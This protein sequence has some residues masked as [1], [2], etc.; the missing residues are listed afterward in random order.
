[1]KKILVLGAG[2]SAPYLIHHLLEHAAEAGTEITV[3]DLDPAAAEARVAG[4]PRG[5]AIPFNLDDAEARR[6]ELGNADLVVHLLPPKLQ[7]VLARYCLEHRCHMASA[8]YLAPEVAEMGDEAKARGVTLLCEL[9]L[10]PGIDLMSAQKIIE[11]A[12]AQGG[13]VESFYSYG[14]GLPEP[15][16]DG[17]PMRYCITWN[18]RNVAM[19][20]E[21]G[22]QYLQD[23]TIKVQPWHRMFGA[24]WP[25]EV[26][27]LGRFD[28]YPNRDSVSYRDTHGLPGVRTL[29][30]GT[31]RYPGFCQAWHQVVRLGLPSEALRIPTLGGM[32]WAQVLEMYLPPGDGTL[33]GRVARTLDLREDDPSLDTLEWLGLFGDTA[34]DDGAR[35][36]TD[37]LVGLMARKLALPDGVRDLVVLHHELEIAYGDRRER[38]LST[39]AH[40]G[41]P[42]GF[43]AMAKGVGLPLALG[44]ELL[45]SGGLDQ[46]GCLGPTDAAVYGPVLDGLARDGLA[47]TESV[48]TL[49][50]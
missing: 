40:Y 6:R 45:I 43:T 47:F 42:G 19:A 18:P 26:P 7:G 17:N 9:G 10:D 2:H 48:Q 20:G 41:E 38:V 24:T 3:G 46:P 37:A 21:L 13:A 23:G 35:H 22:A 29:I 31:L 44:V 14:G 33:R 16:F 27:G 30:R 32:T 4:H 15:S 8:S 12:E 1:M 36:P 5:R 34:V 25:V 50:P 49:D 11:D 39:L 28:A